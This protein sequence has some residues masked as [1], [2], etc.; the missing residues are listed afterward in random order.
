MVPPIHIPYTHKDSPVEAVDHYLT[1]REDIFKEIRNNLLQAQHRM[2][3]R[4]NKKRSERSFS[5]GDSVYVKLQPYR[6][7]SVHKRICHKLSAK[8]YGPY[9][10]IQK[11]GT[12][13]YKLQLP[14]SAAIHPVFHVSQ[15]KQHVGHHAVH[16]D[17]PN[18]QQPSLLQP[19]Q[20]VK[21][22][23]RK[24]GNI[25]ITQLLVVWKDLPLIEATWEDIDDFYF[26]FPEFHLEDKVVIMEGALSRLES[27]KIGISIE[28]EGINSNEA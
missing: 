4:A 27:T 19:L 18:S 24:S 16:S 20:I 7:H 10:I 21:R 13:A 6:Q 28:E 2:T 11:I 25:A 8:Y 17:L 15:L 3:Q 1:L 23:M 22:R 5:M 26:R 12:V 9:T 14:A